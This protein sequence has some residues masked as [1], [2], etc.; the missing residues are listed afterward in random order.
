MAKR[1]DGDRVMVRGP[2]KSSVITVRLS[3]R[4][5]YALDL[6]ARLTGR[7]A[8]AVIEDMIRKYIGAAQI[9]GDAPDEIAAERLARALGGEDLTIGEMFSITWDPRE[10]DRVL[11]IATRVPRLLSDE[12]ELVWRLIK[13]APQFWSGKELHRER[14]RV[15]WDAI[16]RAARKGAPS[17]R[18]LTTKE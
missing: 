8:G 15:H 1:R 9:D 14:V 7:S 11:N 2:R 6:A 5:R 17:L 4:Y 16:V 13:E 12:H 10:C 18:H 3:P